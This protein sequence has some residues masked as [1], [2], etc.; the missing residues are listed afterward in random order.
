M[1]KI[2]IPVEHPFQP[3]ELT[4]FCV[5]IETQNKRCIS[6]VFIGTAHQSNFEDKKY[7]K[8]A[9]DYWV[10]T[11]FVPENHSMIV[12]DELSYPIQSLDPDEAISKQEK[13][14]PVEE[15]KDLPKQE[16]TS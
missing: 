2:I 10:K 13:K 16:Q 11:R 15:V 3:S 5:Q 9:D 1:Q 6:N 7:H 4:S 14:E 8:Y 12:V